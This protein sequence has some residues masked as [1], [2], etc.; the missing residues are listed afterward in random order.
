MTFLIL[1]RSVSPFYSWWSPRS[2]GRSSWWLHTQLINGRDL[3]SPL[4]SKPGS[5][6]LTDLRP[7]AVALD[8][9]II[10]SSSWH[11]W[12]GTPHCCH[13]PSCDQHE[14]EFCWFPCVLYSKCW[15]LQRHR[16]LHLNRCFCL[17][18]IC[19]VLFEP[20]MNSGFIFKNVLEYF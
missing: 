5:F 1:D 11:R 7:R 8:L 10:K 20:W 3:N 12:Y 4:I 14:A 17:D 19:Q 15:G 16:Y 2:S 18:R 6:C 13:C 9:I